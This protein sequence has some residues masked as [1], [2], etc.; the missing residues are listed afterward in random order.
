MSSQQ[1]PMLDVPQRP[2]QTTVVVGRVRTD[3]GDPFMRIAQGSQDVNVHVRLW[4]EATAPELQDVEAEV[5]VTIGTAIAGDVSGADF[6]FLDTLN[7]R[8]DLEVVIVGGAP[9]WIANL[10]GGPNKSFWIGV[11]PSGGVYVD[12]VAYAFKSDSPDAPAGV[13]AQPA[14]PPTSGQGRVPTPTRVS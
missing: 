3:L 8:H 2:G 13:L 4:L 9:G 11:D 10:I 14:T 12:G 5:Y 1:R 6:A 7:R